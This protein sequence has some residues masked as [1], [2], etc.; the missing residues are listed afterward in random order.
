M[1]VNGSTNDDNFCLYCGTPLGEVHGLRRFCPNTI[2]EDGSVN[3]CKDDYHNAMK[4]PKR[5]ATKG[6]SKIHYDN[7]LILHRLYKEGNNIVT[8]EK[9]K[10]AGFRVEFS[11]VRKRIDSTDYFD[12]YY[13]QYLLKQIN[14][15]D[16]K[17]IEHEEQF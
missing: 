10:N 1:K 7:F 5:D 11:I 9:L 2:A 12:A 13:I 6:I 17:I 8:W 3:S 4:K 14:K 16:F 15:T